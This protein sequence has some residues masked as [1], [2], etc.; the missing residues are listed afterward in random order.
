MKN[1]KKGLVIFLA[2]AGLLTG[3]GASTDTSTN[4]SSDEVKASSSSVDWPFYAIESEGKTVGHML[5]S[6]HMGKEDMYPFPDEIIDSLE[7]SSAFYSEVTFSSMTSVHA[8]LAMQEASQ[9]EPL[10]L[11]GM[12]DEAKAKLETN[13]EPYDIKLEDIEELNY[14]GLMTLMQAEYMEASDSLN[15]VDMKLSSIADDADIPNKAFETLEFQL[16]LFQTLYNK[17]PEHD[18]AWY[19][20]L[21]TPEESREALESL[22]N[23]YI[24]GTLEEN[25][26]ELFVENEVEGFS[27]LMLDQRNLDWVEQLK[28]ILPAEDQIFIVVGAGHLYGETGLINQLEMMGYQ[29]T[30]IET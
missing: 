2:G 16:E 24:A 29:V 8:T 17:I 10:V 12:T 9:N 18:E 7:A 25:F 14:Y 11:T 23:H 4:E 19:E 15:G 28:E 22:L 13:L 1:W 5:G 26:D 3:C 27:E 6:I 20:D 30:K 21:G